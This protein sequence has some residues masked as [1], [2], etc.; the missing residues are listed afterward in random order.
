MSTKQKCFHCKRRNHHHRSLCEF[1]FEHVRHNGLKSNG[2]NDINQK[3]RRDTQTQTDE[4]KESVSEQTEV[5]II[6]PQSNIECEYYL[7][8][9]DLHKAKLELAECKK[10][11]ATLKDKISALE[12]ERGNKQTSVTGYTETIDQKTE[13]IPTLRQK[14][15]GLHVRKMSLIVHKNH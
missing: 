9:N 1:K 2:P 12:T 5:E 6:Y 15:E 13:E 10:E 11:N 4:K 3:V 14:L 7:I 8:R